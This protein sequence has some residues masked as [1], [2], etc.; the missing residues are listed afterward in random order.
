MKSFISCLFL[1]LA[2][3]T[4][5]HSHNVYSSFTLIEWNSVDNS[6]ESII[7]IHAHELE[8]KLSVLLNERLTFLE[9]SDY[10]KLEAAT[11]QYI[12]KHIQLTVDSVPTPLT[13]LGMENEGQIIKVYLEADLAETPQALQFMNSIL[14]DDLPGQVNTIVAIVDGKRVGGEITADTGPANFTFK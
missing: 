12:P 4:P 2:H 1:L 8:A 9:D 7:E 11:A 6:I 5:A 14:L 3:Q 13:Y 10:R